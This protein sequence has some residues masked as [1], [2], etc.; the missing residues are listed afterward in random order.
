M[1]DFGPYVNGEKTIG[2]LAEGLAADDLRAL[3]NES[4]DFL[5]SVI[6]VLQSARQLLQV[7]RATMLE[8]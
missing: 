7:C 1:I 5:L 6:E 8:A 4:I 2:Q 3:T